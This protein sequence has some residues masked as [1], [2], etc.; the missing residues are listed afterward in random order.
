MGFTEVKDRVLS[1]FKVEVYRLIHFFL[2][3]F[4]F[5]GSHFYRHVYLCIPRV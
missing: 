4:D 2:T 3:G 5:T 1:Q